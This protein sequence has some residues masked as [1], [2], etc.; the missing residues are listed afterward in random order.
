MINALE[1]TNSTSVAHTSTSNPLL[2][3]LSIL[4]ATHWVSAWMNFQHSCLAFKC[5]NRGQSVL[6]QNLPHLL[7]LMKC[8]DSHKKVALV[9][10]IFRATCSIAFHCCAH[11][12]YKTLVDDWIFAYCDKNLPCGC[13]NKDKKHLFE[14]IT[15]NYVGKLHS[16]NEILMFNWIS[17]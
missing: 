9:L 7:L 15:C 2:T 11:F 8:T 10:R 5:S 1:L 4:N 16:I 14:Y 17:K 3:G 13:A 6:C 12:I